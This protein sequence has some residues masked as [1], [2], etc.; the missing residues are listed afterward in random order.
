VATDVVVAARR[1]SCPTWSGGGGCFLDRWPVKGTPCLPEEDTKYFGSF[2]DKTF[3]PTKKIILNVYKTQDKAMEAEILLHSFYQV[4]VNL[5]FANR[6]R[7]TNKGFYYTYLP[8]DREILRRQNI[9]KRMKGRKKPIE[10]REKISGSKSH[11]YGKRWWNNG[12]EQKFLNEPPA[13]PGWARGCLP[14]SEERKQKMRE[15]HRGK[16]WWTNGKEVKHSKE[17]PAPGWYRKYPKK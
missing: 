5:H 16:V 13:E 12:I 17:M 6:A 7:A 1:S 9:S 2:S 4:D 10:T 11:C 3:K 14:L 15:M 8:M